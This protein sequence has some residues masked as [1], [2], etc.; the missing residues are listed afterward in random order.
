VKTAACNLCLCGLLL[1]ASCALFISCGRLEY[2][3]AENYET[4][5]NRHGETVWSLY[6][7]YPV[8]EGTD[9]AYVINDTVRQ[10]VGF[11]ADYA[12]SEKK[13]RIPDSEHGYF[14]GRTPTYNGFISEVTLISSPDNVLNLRCYYAFTAGES[15]PPFWEDVYYTVLDSETGEMLT[16]SDILGVSEEEADRL[17]RDAL[18]ELI[19]KHPGSFDKNASE[20]VM[21]GKSECTFYIHDG[22]LV[23]LPLPQN[24]ICYWPDISFHKYARIPISLAERN[25]K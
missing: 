19:E 15:S 20:S 21:S 12:R 23:L 5:E 22:D 11:Q 14:E 2:T 8:F 9:A 4:A 18:L 17:I 16:A 24:L 10:M 7:R 13:Y 25:D 3:Y 1:L 6:T